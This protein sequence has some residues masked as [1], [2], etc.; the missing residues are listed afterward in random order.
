MLLTT[1]A[2][3]PCNPTRSTQ[4]QAI[5]D[6]VRALADVPGTN[7]GSIRPPDCGYHPRWRLPADYRLAKIQITAVMKKYLFE[8]S[9]EM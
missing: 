7:G 4:Y 6:Q 8:N 3:I 2:K 5:P 9:N 1:L